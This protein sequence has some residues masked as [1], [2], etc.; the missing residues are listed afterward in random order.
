MLLLLLIIALVICS[1]LLIIL[2]FGL[3]R[4]GRRADEGEEK[5]LDIILSKPT[6][7][8]AENAS[9]DKTKQESSPIPRK[10]HG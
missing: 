3:A 4:A 5:I 6:I 9:Q 8:N 2:L 1:C 7:D 10:Q